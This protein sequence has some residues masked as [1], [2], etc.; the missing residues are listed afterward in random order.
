[1]WFVR[2]V[3][4][5]LCVYCFVCVLGCCLLVSCAFDVVVALLADV[6]CA[7][8]APCFMCLLFCLCSWL[9]C[10]LNCVGI[11]FRVV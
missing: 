4:R 1:M 7:C 2:V 5:V 11:C 9:L 10:C 3:L 8:C 6:V